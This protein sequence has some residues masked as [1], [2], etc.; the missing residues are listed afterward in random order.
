MKRLYTVRAALGALALISFAAAAQQIGDAGGALQWTTRVEPGATRDDFTLVLEARIADGYIVY[1]S[2]F[3]AEL[4][5]R[6]SRLR[7][8]K[9]APVRAE[10][11]LT[12]VDTKRRTDKNL[13]TEYSYF[14]Q[15]AQFRQKLQRTA[16][17]DTLTGRIEGQAC[18]EKDGTCTLFRQVFNLPLSAPPAAPR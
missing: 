13:G 9:E 11:A 15:R 4:G 5:P 7:L 16:A 14:E 3:R 8:D 1:G 12:S 10:G 18:F 6:P 17:G 2:D